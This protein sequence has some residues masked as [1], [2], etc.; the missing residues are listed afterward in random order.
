MARR[1]R[2]GDPSA[3]RR[4]AR[5]P[6]RRL[7]EARQPRRRHDAP[8]RITERVAPGVVYT[9]FHHP[10]TQA[11]VVTTEYSDW[12][13]NCPEYKVTAVQVSPSNGPSDWQEEY[14][15]QAE[16]PADRQ[17]RSGVAGACRRDDKL[18]M[19]ANQIGRFFARAA[20]R[21]SRRRHRRPSA[22]ILGTRACACRHHRPSGRRRRGPGGPVREAMSRMKA[23]KDSRKGIVSQAD[24]GD[25]SFAPARREDA[26]WISSNRVRSAEDPEAERVRRTSSTSTSPLQVGRPITRPILP[27]E[28]D[29]AR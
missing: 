17:G 3:R 9:T 29:A 28:R 25:T 27:E 22:E 16:Q 14:A 8:R 6:R 4:A 10:E 2:A 19:M 13:T 15:A 26:Q 5:R 24:I 18:V 7:G 11:N 21:R 23:A 20:R 12:A 1:G